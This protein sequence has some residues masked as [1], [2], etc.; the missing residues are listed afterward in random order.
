MPTSATR[1][2]K[3]S[4]SAADAPGLALVAVDDHDLVGGPAQ[5]HRPLPQG[6]LAVGG[7][8]VVEHLA[9][10]GLA[11]VQVGVAAQVLGG[12]L[13]RGFGAHLAAPLRGQAWASAIAASTRDEL[14]S[15]PDRRAGA[16]PARRLR[17]AGGGVAVARRAST[18]P[19]RGWQSTPSP[20]RQPSGVAAERPAGAAAR[21]ARRAA[22]HVR[23]GLTGSS[24][25]FRRSGAGPAPVRPSG[26]APAPRTARPMARP[27]RPSAATGRRPAAPRRGRRTSSVSLWARR[28]PGLAGTSAGSPPASSA[29]AA[30]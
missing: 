19:P 26:D 10:R 12:D 24:S 25:A 8:G 4:R 1:R 28:G 11:H 13:R 7:L 9:Q 30:S 2:W 16:R 20:S 23:C 5:R 18:R 27:G 22:P 15:G 21:T 29:A 14:A 6:V 17:G 3:P